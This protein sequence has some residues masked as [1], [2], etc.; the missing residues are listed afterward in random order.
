MLN[1]L[2]IKIPKHIVIACSAWLSRLCTASVQ[3]L[4]IGILL[5]YLGKDDYAVFVLIV[6]LMGWFSLVDMGLGNSI[7]N[8][9]AESRGRKKNYSIYILY[10]GIISIG[11]LFITEFLL[12]IFL[13]FISEIFLGRFGFIANSEA[14]R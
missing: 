4:V 3:F 10:L 2:V 13:E 11:I 12:Y 1:K 5:P 7:Q 14:S 8:F 9:I 6:G